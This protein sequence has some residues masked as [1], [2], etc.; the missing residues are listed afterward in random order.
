MTILRVTHWWSC[1]VTTVRLA[2]THGVGCSVHGW[3]VQRG[4]RAQ[5]AWRASWR[6]ELH[7]RTAQPRS[8]SHH[9]LGPTV[10]QGAPVCATTVL[11]QCV[12]VML[13]CPTFV[14]HLCDNWDRCFHV[15]P[16][17]VQ[18]QSVSPLS[19]PRLV[20]N[21]HW[22]RQQHYNN[23]ATT[24]SDKASHRYEVI[25]DREVTSSIWQLCPIFL[26][27]TVQLYQ[28]QPQLIHR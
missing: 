10:L 23:T 27:L 16:Q 6:V 15:H 26:F 18:H 9:W 11:D 25:E 14:I 8:G 13:T 20:N 1:V 4:I 12:M 21:I 24:Y 5:P 2:G 22:Q 28:Q 19:A 17:C 3:P 7:C